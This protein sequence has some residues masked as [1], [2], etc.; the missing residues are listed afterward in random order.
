MNSDDENINKFIFYRKTYRTKFNW[1]R[2]QILACFANQI[3]SYQYLAFLKVHS[4]LVGIDG[5]I[6]ISS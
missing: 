4:Q 1:H 6:A 2:E 5:A 3:W